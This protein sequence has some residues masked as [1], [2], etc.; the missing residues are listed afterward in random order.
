MKPGFPTRPTSLAAS[1][2]TSASLPESLRRPEDPSPSA[3]SDNPGCNRSRQ[4]HGAPGILGVN[5]GFDQQRRPG[6]IQHILLSIALVFATTA[7]MSVQALSLLTAGSISTEATLAI[8]RRAEAKVRAKAWNEAAALWA[9]AVEA[10]P[11]NGKYWDQLGFSRYSAGEYADA[12]PAFEKSLELRQGY[13]FTAAYNIACCLALQGEKDRAL[14]W[15]SRAMDMGFRDLHLVQT[16]DDLKSLHG[17][18]RFTDLA[19]LA[20]VS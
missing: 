17:D 11:V 10:N 16:D 5:P 20:D 3:I 18:S 9:Q 4:T 14:Q 12:I 1:P 2:E 6:M 8:V 15:L 19:A 13:P 7:S